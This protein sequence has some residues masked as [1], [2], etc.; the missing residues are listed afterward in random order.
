MKQITYVEILMILFLFEFESISA[1]KNEIS[2]AKKWIN[3]SNMISPNISTTISIKASIN[4]HYI[5]A[6]AIIIAI[7]QNTLIVRATAINP[8]ALPFFNSLNFI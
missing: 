7:P 2:Q 8:V 1:T 5:K 6:S 4:H 3:N